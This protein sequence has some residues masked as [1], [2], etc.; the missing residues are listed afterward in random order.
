V[1]DDRGTHSSI[2]QV[3]LEGKP[4]VS[5]DRHPFPRE[6]SFVAIYLIRELAVAVEAS[7]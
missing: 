6:V 4:E 2:C 3:P 1:I 7:W 5:F